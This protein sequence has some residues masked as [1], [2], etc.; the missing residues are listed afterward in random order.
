M[1]EVTR[2]NCLF[3]RKLLCNRS[4]SDAE[5]QREKGTIVHYLYILSKGKGFGVGIYSRERR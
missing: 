3:V 4:K 5:K 1:R 2:Q